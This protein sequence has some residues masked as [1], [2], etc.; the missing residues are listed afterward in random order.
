MPIQGWAGIAELV[1]RVGRTTAVG[2]WGPARTES[3]PT[4]ARAVANKVAGS[5]NDCPPGR[6]ASVGRQKRQ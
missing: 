4:A 6:R 3:A 2:M 5:W 1:G